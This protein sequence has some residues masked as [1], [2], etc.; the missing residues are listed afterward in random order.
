MPTFMVTLAVAVVSTLCGY[1]GSSLGKGPEL[2]I[3][4]MVTYLLVTAMFGFVSTCISVNGAVSNQGAGERSVLFPAIV[5]YLVVGALGLVVIADD[6]H[7]ILV[8]VAYF[9]V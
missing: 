8:T 2:D 6:S 4:A 5:I 1:A 9:V 3:G 7:S